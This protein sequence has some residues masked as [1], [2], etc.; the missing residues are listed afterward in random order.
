MKRVAPI[1]VLALSC[2]L[3]PSCQAADCFQEAAAFHRV[4]ADILRAIARIESAFDQKAVGNNTNGTQDLGMMQINSVH[5]PELVNQGIAPQRL[6]DACTSIYV[7]AWHYARQVRRYGNTWK[8]VG[9]YHS[10]TPA[11]RDGYARR[12]REVVAAWRNEGRVDAPRIPSLYASTL[13]AQRRADNF[14]FR[15]LDE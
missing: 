2:L 3:V 5:F 1:V 11:L 9:A 7:A 10:A 14:E 13:A 15:W 12:V 8:A 6:L 4:D